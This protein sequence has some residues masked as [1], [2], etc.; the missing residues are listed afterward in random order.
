MELGSLPCPHPT[1]SHAWVGSYQ[2]HLQGNRPEPVHPGLPRAE[3]RLCCATLAQ[4]TGCR[5]VSERA[6]LAGAGCQVVLPLGLPPMAAST[7]ANLKSTK[8]TAAHQRW[9]R[10][11]HPHCST[12]GVMHV[13][14]QPESS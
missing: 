9:G 5:L 1:C 13:R 7:S 11:A 8:N 12:G 2:L 14:F 4:A 6:G 10:T 3:A